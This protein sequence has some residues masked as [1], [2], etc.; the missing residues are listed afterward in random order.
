MADTNKTRATD[1]PVTDFIA[2]V[3]DP[4][5]RADAGTLVALIEE[6]SGEPA[7][8]WGPSLIGCG[9]YIYRYD[10]GRTGEIFRIG[11]SPRKAALVLYLG[12][13]VISDPGL[14]GRLGKHTSGKG[15]LYIKRLADVDLAVVREALT[16][17]WQAT[18][19]EALEAVP[20]PEI[21]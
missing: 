8:L 17:S 15:C 13:R 12:Q 6:I 10:S 3:P 21:P 7:R 5:R 19:T 20:N 11:F 1:V 16:R 4:V 2:G 18:F 14:M 9:A